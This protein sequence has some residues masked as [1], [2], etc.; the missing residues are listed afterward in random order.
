MISEIIDIPRLRVGVYASTTLTELAFRQAVGEFVRI[1][2]GLGKQKCGV[3]HAGSSGSGQIRAGDQSR[4]R[5]RFG[6]PVL[7]ESFV[8]S[9]AGDRIRAAGKFRQFA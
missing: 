8:K 5:S 6:V 4:A 7:S 3:L 9:D 1:I 2:A